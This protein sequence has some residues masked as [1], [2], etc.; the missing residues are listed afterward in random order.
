VIGQL[1]RTIV[2]SYYGTIQLNE[3]E[4][5]VTSIP[6][7]NQVVINVNSTNMNPFIASPSYGPTLPQIKAIGDINS[8]QINMGRSGNLT[9]IPGSFIDIS[10]A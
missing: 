2:P 7:L 6:A 1:V 5:Y 10:P 3:V 8:G 9:W 4:G